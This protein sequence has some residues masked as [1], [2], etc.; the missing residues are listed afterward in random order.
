M[1]T[2]SN[3]RIVW[4]TPA[5]PSDQFIVQHGIEPLAAMVA[6]VHSD[7]M[8]NLVV[9]DSQGFI[10]ARTSVTLLQDDDRKPEEGRFCAWM[11]YQKA[12]AS[13]QIAP[14]MHAE[15]KSV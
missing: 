3:G 9:F 11:P 6:H 12:V 13:G 5:R 7:R 14:T 2:P 1:I 15:P 10:H 4:Y 8:V